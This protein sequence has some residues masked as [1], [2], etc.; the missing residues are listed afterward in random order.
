M[1]TPYEAVSVTAGARKILRGALQDDTGKS[2]IAL[3]MACDKP[4]GIGF[5]LLCDLMDLP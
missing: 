4:V 5:L 1:S 3:N 2:E